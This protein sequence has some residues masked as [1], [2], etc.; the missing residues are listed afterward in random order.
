MATPDSSR[1]SSPVHSFHD[2]VAAPDY[3]YIESLAKHCG[4]DA[5]RQSFSASPPTSPKTSLS[6]KRIPEES[7]AAIGRTFS[8]LEKVHPT[9]KRRPSVVSTLM[10]YRSRR[11][12]HR[13]RTPSIAS[14]ELQSSSFYIPVTKILKA[15][16]PMGEGKAN[17]QQSP[18]IVKHVEGQLLFF[19]ESRS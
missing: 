15:L 3:D 11:S 6:Q 5:L 9:P 17:Q 13:K 16:G 7:K 8:N 12:G 2:H 10:S 19:L 4:D 18:A 1:S 14:S